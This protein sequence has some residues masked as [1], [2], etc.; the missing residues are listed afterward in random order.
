MALASLVGL[1]LFLVPAHGVSA[2][3]LAR[4]ENFSTDDDADVEVYGVN[5][6]G[7]TFTVGASAHTVSQVRIK[8]YREGTL[9]DYLVAEI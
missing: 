1:L 2:L 3:T 6:Y 7:Q 9:T 4:Y 8:A 5:W